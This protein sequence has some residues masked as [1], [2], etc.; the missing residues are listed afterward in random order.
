MAEQEI[1]LFDR[2]GGLGESDDGQ[3]SMDESS[4]SHPPGYTH[5]H[6]LDVDESELEPEAAHTVETS[7]R[8]IVRLPAEIA[9]L[10]YGDDQ[11]LPEN[12]SFTLEERQH[13]LVIIHAFE[14]WTGAYFEH[15]PFRTPMF[16]DRFVGRE[17]LTDPDG[18]RSRWHP[19]DMISQLG[20]PESISGWEV[21]IYMIRNPILNTERMALIV[22]YTD[23]VNGSLLTR[24]E[25][26][27]CVLYDFFR[28]IVSGVW[29]DDHLS[30]VY[31]PNFPKRLFQTQE[32]VGHLIEYMNRSIRRTP[33]YHERIH[34]HG[35][36]SG[37]SKETE[38]MTSDSGIRALAA[39]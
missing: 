31:S 4:M 2:G 17:H 9:N 35:F 39:V 24:V 11:W 21:N 36:R 12:A 27:N 16:R 25:R 30:I 20:R 23:N 1:V 32:I 26:F 3:D 14:S 7:R 8:R 34:C 6:V 38:T 19:S 28:S 22:V 33:Q 10:R 13:A 15:G 29:D 5:S 18:P 37:A